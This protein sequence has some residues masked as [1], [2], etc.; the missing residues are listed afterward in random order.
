MIWTTQPVSDAGGLVAAQVAGQG[1][2]VMLIH[3]VGLQGA[4]MQPLGAH[5]A[6]WFCVHVVDMPGHG[7]SPL[8]GA[9]ALPDYIDRIGRYGASLGQ[10]FAVVGHSMG[11]MVALGLAQ[12]WPDHVSHVAALNAIYRRSPQAAK[13]VQARAAALSDSVV[14]DPAPTLE[15]WFG[16]Q[17][18]GALAGSA[19]SC[20]KMLTTV[21]PLGYK[22][23]YQVFASEDGPSDVALRALS[24]PALFLTGQGD[25]NSTPA[26]SQ[27]MARLT[28]FGQSQVVPD[29][30]HMLP[31]THVD[32][33]VGTLAAFLRACPSPQ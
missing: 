24:C 1:P 12:R 10:R 9:N 25:V 13:A 5:L 6:Q 22:T 7:A 3:G 11:A 26:M 21:D 15:R 33:V 29:A 14:S 28:P 27:A 2:A 19:Q 8:A 18:E 31:M 30:A 23:A 17:P 20:H 4:S 16:A 32:Q